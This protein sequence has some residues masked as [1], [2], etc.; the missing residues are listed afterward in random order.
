MDAHWTILTRL[1]WARAVAIM[2]RLAHICP[3]GA[4][5]LE[6]LVCYL[7]KICLGGHKIFCCNS[8]FKRN[9]CEYTVLIVCNL[10]STSDVLEGRWAGKGGFR[11][12]VFSISA[13]YT[14]LSAD[15]GC[16][17]GCP[18]GQSQV[19]VTDTA[20]DGH[21]CLVGCKAFC[22]DNPT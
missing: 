6:R 14:F 21:T 19:S 12:T 4:I 18:S 1:L 22:C 17:N 15:S 20:G 5:S 8:N 10:P 13:I 7:G 3:C 11:H 9:N 16:H 2:V